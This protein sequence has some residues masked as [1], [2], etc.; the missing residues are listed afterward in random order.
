[1]R[2]DL[3]T[4][5]NKSDGSDT[6]AELVERAKFVGLDIVA[7]TDHDLADGWNEAQAAADRVGIRLV[8]GME[9]SAEHSG[10]GIH[11]LAYELD[12]EYPPLLAELE[13][14]LTARTRRIP[15]ILAK[16]AE[17]GV[18]I[19]EADVAAAQGDA[20]S[21]GRPHIAD[22]M[23]AK[24]YVRDRR[25]AFDEW[26]GDG[27]PGRVHKYNVPVFDAIRLV[28]EA[29][30]IPVVAHPWGR[31]SADVMTPEFFAELEAAGLAGIEVD[32]NDHDAFQRE[33]LREIAHDL[34]LIVTGSSDY[35]G[36]GKGPD[37]GLGANTTDP[38]EFD[39]L[40]A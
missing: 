2:I 19:T 28:R 34:D 1:M 11:L 40:L 29:G 15:L 24:N 39:K 6:P 5:S 23:I 14:V 21:A 36:T 25:E 35:H 38:D 13:K 33:R 22:A 8:K 32:H 37:F 18:V 26:L 31:G 30:G 4:H 12:P 17:H 16:L 7:L 27:R 10:K 20:R 9:I 3:H